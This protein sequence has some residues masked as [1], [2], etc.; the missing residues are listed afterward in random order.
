VSRLRWTTAGESHGPALVGVLEG[1]PSGLALSTERIDAELQR[2]QR[3]YGRG[4]RMKIESDR[5]QVLAGWR[6][7]RTI[8]SPLALTLENRDATLERLPLPP[9]PRPGHADL[10]GCQKHASHDA[11]AVLERASARETAMRVALGGAARQVLEAF[12]IELFAHVIELGGSAARADA[13]EAAGE[14]RAELRGASEFLALDATVEASWR[15]RVDEARALGDTLGGVFEVRVLGLPP[16]L[17]GYASPYERLTARLGAALLSI[18]AMKGVEF[19]LGFES[20]R[21]LGSEVH[22]AI[23]PPPASDPAPRW[24]KFARAS[25][26]SG[27][28]EGGMTTGEP[29]VARVAMKPIA[30]LRRGLPTVEFESGAAVDST[31]QRSDVTSVPAASVVG[32]AVLA[33]ELASVFLGRFAGDSFEQVERSFEHYVDRLRH[34]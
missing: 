3:G 23:V 15:A 7:G 31:W 19:G 12:G 20:A 6:A 33:L 21:R 25:N 18:P 27:G 28:L 17:G 2:R 22:D 34:L 14:R 13:F 26:R 9:S 10:A 8:G 24:G 5:V 30:T 32:E 11:R 1:L 4:G 16:G 29:L